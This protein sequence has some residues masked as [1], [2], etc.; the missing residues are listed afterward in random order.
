MELQDP[1]VVYT[2]ASNIEAHEIAEMLQ[3]HGIPSHVIEDNTPHSMWMGGLNSAIHKPQVWVSKT[4]KETALNHMRKYDA[5]LRL[6]DSANRARL[7]PLQTVLFSTCD[8][9]GH[10]VQFPVA[11]SGTVQTC[12][13]CAAYMDVDPDPEF[14]DWDVGEPEVTVTTDDEDAEQEDE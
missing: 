9:C 13:H 14:G 4:D 8:R 2:A 1:V 6:R 10:E 7:N 12:P 5:R 3:T 11:Q